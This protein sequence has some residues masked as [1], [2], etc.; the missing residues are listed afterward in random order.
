MTATGTAGIDAIKLAQSAIS[1]EEIVERVKTGETALFAVLMRRYNRRLYRVARA[2]LGDESEAEDVMQDA[3]VRSYTHLY[4]FDGRAKFSTWLTKIAVYEAGKRARDRR[5]F[6]EVDAMKESGEDAMLVD[7]QTPSPDQEL[8]TRALGMALE[9]AIERLPE[10]YSSVFMLREVEGLST[11]ETADCLGISDDAVKVRLHRA[12]GLLRKDILLHTG[13]AT[14]SAFQFA[15]IRCDRVVEAVLQQ[16]ALIGP[17]PT[18][19]E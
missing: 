11:A 14:T 13:A 1:D 16:I 8:L 10:T 9:A 6:V 15:G 2:I 17:L 18:F 5:R 7:S 4:Q 19:L 12:R 3:F